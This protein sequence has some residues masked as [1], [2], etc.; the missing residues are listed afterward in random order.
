MRPV[1]VQC[2]ALWL[3]TTGLVLG[4]AAQGQGLLAGSA[5]RGPACCFGVTR[6][7]AGAAVGSEPFWFQETMYF[8]F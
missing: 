4:T 1:P 2:G 8:H 6:H 5:Q 3:G 7:A